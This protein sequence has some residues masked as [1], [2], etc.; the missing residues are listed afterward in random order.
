MSVSYKPEGYHTAT[1]YLIVDGADAALAFYRDAFGAEELF[2]LPM[3]GKVGHAEFKIGDSLIMI[4]DEWPDM[5]IRGPKSRGGPTASMVLYVE[6]VDAAFDRAIAAGASVD[7]PVQNEFWGDRMGTVL[8]PYGHKW[9][10]ATH[11]EDVPQDQLQQR[12]QAWA[13]SQAQGR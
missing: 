6:D 4:S 5:G 12:M 1:P 7:R 10:L 2:R 11:V 9:S 8:D 13:Q 3:D